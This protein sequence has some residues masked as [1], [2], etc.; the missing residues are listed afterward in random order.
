MQFYGEALMVSTIVLFQNPNALPQ[1]FEKN[2]VKRRNSKLNQTQILSGSIF[3]TPASLICQFLFFFCL[4]PV[5]QCL[6]VDCLITNINLL[7]RS[8]NTNRKY[9]I[10]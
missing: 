9:M 7:G 5:F 3:A 2:T 10:L 1:W 4:S 8:I 6:T